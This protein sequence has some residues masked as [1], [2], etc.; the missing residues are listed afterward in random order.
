MA[1]KLG[2]TLTTFVGPLDKE[3]WWDATSNIP[4]PELWEIVNTIAG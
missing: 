4:K 1:Y 2:Q 3:T